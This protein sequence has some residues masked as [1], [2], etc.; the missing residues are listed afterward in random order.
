MPTVY[1]SIRAMLSRMSWKCCTG[2]LE[3]KHNLSLYTFLDAWLEPSLFTEI[4]VAA[5]H[6]CKVQ[7]HADNIQER[8]SAAFIEHSQ[9]VNIGVWSRIAPCRGAEQRQAHDTGLFQLPFMGA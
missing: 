6:F 5:E 1:P 9:Q 2:S 8:D 7:L 3:G 4:D